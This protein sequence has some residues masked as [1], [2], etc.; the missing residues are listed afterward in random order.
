M[1]HELLKLWFEFVLQWHYVGV[2]LLMAL[3]STIFP[4]PSEIIIPP[5]AYWASQGQMNFW[6]VVVAGMLGSYVGSVI[7]YL[8]AH[9]IGRPLLLKFGKY[10]LVT[11]AKLALAEQWATQYATVGI[12]LARMLPVVRHLISI[13]AGML[14]MP[15]GTFSLA[16][17]AGS[18]LWC[19]VLAWFGQ[20]VIGDQPALLQDPAILVQVLKSKLIYFVG[21]VIVM[22]ALYFWMQWQKHRIRTVV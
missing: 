13:P 6:G 3:E 19:W 18:G 1:F 15:F 10:F 4:I 20:Q 5:A 7:S 2:A 9:W 21:A 22:G 8:A 17:L 16:T 12:F 11:P 14:R